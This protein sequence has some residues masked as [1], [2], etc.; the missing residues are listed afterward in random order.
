MK[1]IKS[2]LAKKIIIILVVLMIFNIAIP[3]KV[4]AAWNFTGILMKPINTLLLG[5]LVSID[6][7]LGL[8]IQGIDLAAERSRGD[9]T[10]NNRCSR[11]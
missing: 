2:D 8:F 6:V 3:K 9:N 11:Y 7:Q 5:F 4:H 10:T 1:F